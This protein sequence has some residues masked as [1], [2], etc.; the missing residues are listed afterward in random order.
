MCFVLIAGWTLLSGS[1]WLVWLCMTLLCAA[2]MPLHL[3]CMLVRNPWPGLSGRSLW[4]LLRPPRLYLFAGHMLSGVGLALLY[5]RTMLGF[6][7]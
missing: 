5:A 2:L 1:F 4:R 7:R 6:P 3:Q